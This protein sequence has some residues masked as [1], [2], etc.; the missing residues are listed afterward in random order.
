MKT[1]F[2]MFAILLAIITLGD[3]FLLQQSPQS[4]HMSQDSSYNITLSKDY[5]ILAVSSYCD[6]K[7]I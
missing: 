7:C 3:S 4:Q 2:L 5:A 6:K 1:N